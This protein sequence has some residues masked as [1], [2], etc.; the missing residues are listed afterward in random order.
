MKRT[1]IFI[2]FLLMLL[3]SCTEKPVR[4][5]VKEKTEYPPTIAGPY[6]NAEEAVARRNDGIIGGGI[7]CI[8]PDGV[9]IFTPAIVKLNRKDI[10]GTDINPSYFPDRCAYNPSQS[11]D[12]VDDWSRQGITEIYCSAYYDHGEKRYYHDILVPYALRARCPEGY[13]CGYS[14]LKEG[15]KE[16]GTTTMTTNLEDVEDKA[17][18]CVPEKVRIEPSQIDREIRARDSTRPAS[19]N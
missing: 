7:R 13:I 12:K 10:Y 2:L 4:D 16:D 6:I 5:S 15:A 18:A 1:I 17:A 8:D 3:V 11:I 9:D 14:N 19:R